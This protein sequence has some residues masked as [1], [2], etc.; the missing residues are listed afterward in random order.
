MI[1]QSSDGELI[2]GIAQLTGWQ[3]VRGSSSKD[4]AKALRQMVRKL[5]ETTLAAHLVDGPRGPAGFVKNGAVHL[6]KLT[7]ALIV[8][9][10]AIPER[11]WYFNSWD[12]FCL[13]KPFSKVILR[14]G[15]MISVHD[16]SS[17]RSL[18]DLRQSLETVMLAAC[19]PTM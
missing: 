8:P 9:A 5:R 6:A 18:E 15:D 3:T 12:H 2:A 11:A 14:F 4:G 16:G 17:D 10:Y 19:R 13:P 7:G 1:S